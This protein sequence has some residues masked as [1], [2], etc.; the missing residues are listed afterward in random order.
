M[1]SGNTARA[2]TIPGLAMVP[3]RDQALPLQSAWGISNT[4]RK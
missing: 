4:W 3:S 1:T 2:T